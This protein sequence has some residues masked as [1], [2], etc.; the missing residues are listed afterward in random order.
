M[1]VPSLSGHAI[2][3]RWRSLSRVCRDRT[4]K[5]QGSSERVLPWQVNM[6]QSLCASFPHTHYKYWCEV[7]MLKVP[8][9]LLY[10]TTTTATAVGQPRE[11]GNRCITFCELLW[12]FHKHFSHEVYVHIIGYM[13]LRCTY[14]RTFV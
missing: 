8:A 9:V 11:E 6:G 7:D 10:S 1:S 12:M 14:S 2:A 5:H 3:Y 13:R 4:I